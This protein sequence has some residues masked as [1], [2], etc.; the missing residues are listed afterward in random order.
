MKQITDENA[1]EV[2]AGLEIVER[3]LT[4]RISELHEVKGGMEARHVF[5]YYRKLLWESSRLLCD[6][7]K[8]V[9]K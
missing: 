8:D 4:E 6:N 2:L 5:T 9:K 3:L 7:L 1:K